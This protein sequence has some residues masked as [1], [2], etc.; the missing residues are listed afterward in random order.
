MNGTWHDNF[1]GIIP[2]QTYTARLS[3]GEEKGLVVTL[4][5]DQFEITIRFGAVHAVQ[6][7]D[8]GV[9]LNGKVTEQLRILRSQGFPSTIYEIENGDFGR[10]IQSQMGSEL[11][12]ALGCR[13]YNMV[14]LNYVICVASLS[15]PEIS[16]AAKQRPTL[17]SQL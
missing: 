1:Q 17:N 13:Q 6:M 15:K 4:D 14:T 7:L 3:A 16:I 2:R 12:N 5:S 10:F 11:Y 8:E 9:Q